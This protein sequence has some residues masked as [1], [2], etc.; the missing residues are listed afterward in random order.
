[1][2]REPEES[3]ANDILYDIPYAL[4]MD[5]IRHHVEIDVRRKGAVK[6]KALPEGQDTLQAVVNKRIKRLMKA[7]KKAEPTAS[8]SKPSGLK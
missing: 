2:Y 6:R 3:K 4:L 7:Q 1:M 8:G 5:V